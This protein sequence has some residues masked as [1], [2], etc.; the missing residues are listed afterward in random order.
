[1][2]YAT[3]KT[4]GLNHTYTTEHKSQTSMAL[5][6]A[7]KLLEWG[8]HKAVLPVPYSFLSTLMIYTKPL[9]CILYSLLMTPPFNVLAQTSTHSTLWSIGISNLLKTGSLQTN[10]LLMQ[11]KQSTFSFITKSIT[12][13]LALYFLATKL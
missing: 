11:K 3:K 6:L 4:I 10:S 8:Y 12:F 1:M 9:I 13:T 7:L 2:A 5:F